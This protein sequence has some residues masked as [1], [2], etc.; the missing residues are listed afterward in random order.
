MQEN[1]KTEPQQAVSDSGRICPSSRSYEDLVTSANR[2]IAD[3][4]HSQQAGITIYPAD[5]I[6]GIL[7]TEL[8]VPVPDI[9]VSDPVG[10]REL[11]QADFG[12][13]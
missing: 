5:A 11:R 2:E 6:A 10:R 4:S 8:R 3:L 9:D 13:D 1:A 12:I 7:R